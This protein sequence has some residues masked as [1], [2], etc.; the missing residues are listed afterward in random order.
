ML[1]RPRYAGKEVWN[2]SR[3]IKAPGTNK[4][5]RRARPRNE[6]R[7][8]DRPELR[9]VSAELWK[10]VQ[11]RLAQVKQTYGNQSR[12][13]LLTRAASSR[14]L[15]SGFLKCASCGANLTIVSGRSGDRYP[16]YGCPQNFYRGTCLNDLK[17]RQDWLEDRLLSQLQSEVFKPEVID[18][19]VQ[20]FG[21]QLEA[22]LQNLSGE[23]ARMREQKEKLESEL[24]RLTAPIAERGHSSFLLAAIAEREDKL[25]EITDRLLSGGVGPVGSGGRVG[26]AC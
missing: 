21:R 16:R 12:Q 13:G 15:L 4:R 19:A 11:D 20:E 10:S 25:R 26:G 14:Y 17:E 24:R 23:T 6:W 1:R 5:L 9:I 7:I 8:G 22:A 18:Y 2:R 3:F